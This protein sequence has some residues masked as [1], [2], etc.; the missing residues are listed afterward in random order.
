MNIVRLEGTAQQVRARQVLHLSACLGCRA[1]ALCVDP[2]CW[3]SRRTCSILLHQKTCKVQWQAMLLSL[4]LQLVSSRLL[5]LSLP[6]GKCKM[7][8]FK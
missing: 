7:H 5:S 1:G 6:G 4:P 2:H 8:L 3:P